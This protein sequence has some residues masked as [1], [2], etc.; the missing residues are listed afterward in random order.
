MRWDGAQA[1]TVPSCQGERQQDAREPSEQSSATHGELPIVWH[2]QPFKGFL[3][4][5]TKQ[6]I[7]DGQ[8]EC[9]KGE[10]RSKKPAILIFIIIVIKETVT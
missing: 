4:D 1:P 10:S 5:F 7:K 3:L 6:D 8:K 2:E 9:S